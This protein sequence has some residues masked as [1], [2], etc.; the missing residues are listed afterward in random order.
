MLLPITLCPGRKGNIM[1]L[2]F[3]FLITS[4]E[5]HGH[6]HNIQ[7]CPSNPKRQQILQIGNRKRIAQGFLTVYGSEI[8]IQSLEQKFVYSETVFLACTV[9]GV[10]AL[11]LLLGVSRNYFHGPVAPTV[12]SEMNSPGQCVLKNVKFTVILHCH[13]SY[14]SRLP[15]T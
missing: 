10:Q 3:C 2:C 15:T 4:W 9:R 1:A 11:F 14:V 5:I 7:M 13:I 12:S 6:H 8:N